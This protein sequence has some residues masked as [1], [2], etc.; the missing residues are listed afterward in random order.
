MFC[1]TLAAKAVLGTAVACSGLT[2]AAHATDW[3]KVEVKA[4]VVQDFHKDWNKVVVKAPVATTLTANVPSTFTAGTSNTIQLHLVNQY[5]N[6]VTGTKNITITGSATDAS[7]NGTAA[8]LPTTATFDSNGNATVNATLVNAG[9]GTIV[10]NDTTDN[11]STTTATTVNAAAA[12]S[13]SVSPVTTTIAPGATTQVVTATVLDADGNPVNGATVNWSVAAGTNSRTVGTLSGTSSTTGSNGQAT[14]TYTENAYGN[15]TDV[16][17]ATVTGASTSAGTSTITHNYI[18]GHIYN[19]TMFGADHHDHV[20]QVNEQT[21]S[22][23][24]VR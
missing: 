1:S 15:G 9:V 11:L 18:S 16:V 22:C 23:G 12:S 24:C 19:F 21:G 17:T 8:T 7:P 20:Y 14:I 2:G 5:G 6:P 13:F 3:H 4:P 10:V